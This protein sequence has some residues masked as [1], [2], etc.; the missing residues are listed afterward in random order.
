MKIEWIGIIPLEPIKPFQE[1]KVE[2]LTNCKTQVTVYGDTT[3]CETYILE[4]I[5]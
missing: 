1:C 5:Q 2:T 4:D 3:N